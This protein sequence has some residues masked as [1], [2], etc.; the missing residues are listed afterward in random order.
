MSH[1]ETK[2]LVSIYRGGWGTE[3]KHCKQEVDN[4]CL[5]TKLSFVPHPVLKE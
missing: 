4:H 2:I 1:S 3:D 5:R